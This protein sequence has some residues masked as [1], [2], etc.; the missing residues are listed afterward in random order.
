MLIINCEVFLVLNWSADCVI[1]YAN[2]ANHIPIFTITETNFYAPV[3]TLS[4]EDNAI[5]IR[6]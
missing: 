4:T 1:I 2:V 5:R 3:L 6:F